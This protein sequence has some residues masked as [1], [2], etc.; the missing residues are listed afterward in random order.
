MESIQTGFVTDVG[1]PFE[2]SVE[3]A[4]ECDFDFIELFMEGRFSRETVDE[5]RQ[6]Y[7]NHLDQSGL[8]LV[9][10]LPFS[11]DIGS[12]FDRVRHASVAELDACLQLAAELGATKAVVH[13]T[14][15]AWDKAWDD[16]TLQPLI[17]DSI[18]ELT[19]RAENYG[20]ELCAENIFNTQFTIDEFDTLLAETTTSMTLDTGHARISDY[21]GERLSSFVREYSDRI[22]HVHLN[23]SRYNKDEHLPFGAGNFDFQSLF[24]TLGNCNW[25]GTLSLEIH[26][27]NLEYLSL[28]KDQLD[29]T[30]EGS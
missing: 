1:V 27:E 26:S 15:S 28:S 17:I 20:V 19:D 3:V 10:H 2:H 7:Q 23:D 5:N 14:A 25:Q 4:T 29:S 30:L 24:E 9:V 8:S 22:S 16:E 6:S 21:T 12:P 11:L 18:D 13:P